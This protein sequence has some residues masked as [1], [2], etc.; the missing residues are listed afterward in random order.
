MPSHDIPQV[1]PG[2]K[3]YQCLQYDKVICKGK[4]EVFL[5]EI[6]RISN[7]RDEQILPTV[8]R[9]PGPRAE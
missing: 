7:E 8:N 4:K 9:S 3:L 2:S 6:K 1:T 5:I